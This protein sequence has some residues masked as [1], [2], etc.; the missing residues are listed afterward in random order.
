[1]GIEFSGQGPADFQAFLAREVPKW[2][3]VVKQ[4]GAR[5]D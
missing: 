2:A 5:I 4:S 3:A 1:M